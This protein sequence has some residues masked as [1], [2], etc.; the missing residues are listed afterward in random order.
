MSWLCT[1]QGTHNSLSWNL[2]PP[3]CIKSNFGANTVG[4]IADANVVDIEVSLEDDGKVKE[5]FLSLGGIVERSV[6]DVPGPSGIGST[7]NK[8]RHNSPKTETKRFRH[9]DSPIVI[10]KVLTKDNEK[11]T[12][13]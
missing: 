10:R 4:P 7:K 11:V 9:S 1:E 5:G 3:I 8:F 13:L 6:D 12:Y 2:Y